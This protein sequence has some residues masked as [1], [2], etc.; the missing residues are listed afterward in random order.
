MGV[1]RFSKR[2]ENKAGELK[3]DV[4]PALAHVRQGEL[5]HGKHL[6]D[7]AAERALDI[8]EVDLGEVLAHHLLGRVVN[9]DVDGAER[10]DMLLDGLLALGVV[11]QVAGDQQALV[12]LLLDHF[13]G[14]LGVR[15]LLGEVDD[16]D[17]GA[18]AGEQDGD[19]AANAGTVRVNAESCTTLT[20]N[21]TLRQ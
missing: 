14:V 18:L 11:H 4:R 3:G 5:G 2:R 16:A 7:V 13:L 15:L 17:V 1:T 8:V 10:V 19:G 12:A 9:Q 20:G 21:L 6:Q